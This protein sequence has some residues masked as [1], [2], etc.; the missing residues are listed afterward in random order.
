MATIILSFAKNNIALWRLLLQQVVFGMQ[1]IY[2]EKLK[3]YF[4]RDR[5]Y[6]G[7]V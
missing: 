4:S 1:R 6:W 2:S 3:E 5:I 7:M